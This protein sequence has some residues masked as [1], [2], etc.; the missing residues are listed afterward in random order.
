M[1]PKKKGPA[2]DSGKGEKLFKSLC[3]ICHAMGSNG[4]GPALKG[5][6]GRAPGGADGFA[7]S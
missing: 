7:Y 4:T 6:F 1:A 5:V 3:A 2:G